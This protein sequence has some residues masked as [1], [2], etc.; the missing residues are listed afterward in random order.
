MWFFPCI[1]VHLQ[2][3]IVKQI[4]TMVKYIKQEMPDLRKDG[5]KKCYYRMQSYGNV[6]TDELIH[7]IC[8][9]GGVGLSESVFRHA[10][11]DLADELACKIA[12]GYSVTLDGIGTF[13][14]AIGV[15]EDKDMDTLDGEETKRNAQS[16][17]L[18][19]INYKADGLLVKRARGRCRLERA[20]TRRVNPS[21][22]TKD[23]R[24][25]M[26]KGFLS[27][28][29]HPYMKT[30]DYARM[31]HLP[32]STASKEL[33]DFVSDPKSG[34]TSSGKATHIVYVLA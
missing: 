18:K 32:K 27:D 21:P 6:T 13:R 5:S 26:A 10:L 24:L 3:L 28:G 20:G 2:W 1:F 9:H 25:Q 8:L 14:A 19:R 4:D 16:L 7:T 23:E 17:E 12:E 33:R 31:T 30:D 29:L 34:I 22:Y 15:R 11:E